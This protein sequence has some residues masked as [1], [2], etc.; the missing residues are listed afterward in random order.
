MIDYRQEEGEELSN[1]SQKL[2]SSVDRRL[3]VGGLVE[4]K[5][6]IDEGEWC[7]AHALEIV[8]APAVDRRFYKRFLVFVV[9]GS[10]TPSP[11]LRLASE[12]RNFD[13]AV[14]FYEHPGVNECLI[15][16]ADFVMTGGLSKF[17][18]AAQFIAASGVG[19]KYEGYLF[20]DGDLEFDVFKLNNF[21]CMVQAANFDLAQPSVSRD[22]YC[23]WKVAYHQP[24][25]V[26][27]E[28]SFVEVMAP[29][30]SRAALAKLLPTF[31]QSISSYGLDFVW[32]H[33]LGD[34]KIGV[35]DGFQMRHS[36]RVDL[37]AGAF[38]RYLA[39]LGIDPLE[40]GRRLEL[41]YGVRKVRP[42]SRR[43]YIGRNSDDTSPFIVSVPLPHPERFTKSQ[44]AIDLT[45]SLLS[46]GHSRPEAQ[47]SKALR[48]C[49]DSL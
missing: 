12:Q 47:L 44:G 20:L 13:L 14:R 10:L 42:Y 30:M 17:H 25:F 40:E 11:L 4:Y 38:Y 32:P 34:G 7:N 33:L 3:S 1:F 5:S 22:S 16:E 48:H 6:A 29:F 41:E 49:L 15:E 2:T 8:K 46:R 37:E 39:T 36:D 28:T 18:S 19:D 31:D 43:G 26:F 23:Y 35:V 27:R 9:L 21:L 24:R 45:M